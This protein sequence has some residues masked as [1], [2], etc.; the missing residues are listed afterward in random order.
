MIHQRLEQA[1]CIPPA[2]LLVSDFAATNGKVRES[3][4][5]VI[6]TEGESFCQIYLRIVNFAKLTQD[7]Q[8]WEGE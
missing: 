1:W 3:E 6:P 5:L 4:N 7:F 2:E 8:I